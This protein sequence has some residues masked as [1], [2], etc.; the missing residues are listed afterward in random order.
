MSF[1]PFIGR[2]AELKLLNELWVSQKAS[3]LLLYG[4]RRVGKTR[5]LTHWQKSTGHR[6]LYWVASPSSALDQLRSFSHA[7]YNFANPQAKAPADFT[8]ATW[9]QA[10]QQVANLAHQE[11]LA[12]FVDEFT[13]LLEVD[14]SLA[15][16]L[17]NVWDH[18]LKEANLLLTLSGSHLGMMQRHAL[19]YQAPLYGRATAQLHLQ[20]LPFGVTSAF[21]P[22]YQVAERVAIYA[23]FGG[24]PA[25]WERLDQSVSISENIRRQLLTPNNLMQAEPR[26]LLADF[27]SQ[28]HNYVGIL[29]AI[30]QG[31]RLQK[32]I[33][34]RTGL[35][36]GHISKYLSV[37]REAGFVERRVSVT[38][39]GRSRNGRYHITDPY[40]RFYYRFLS[41][42]QAQL[43]L[44]VH[45]QALEEIKR[46]LLDFIGTH[47]WEELSR[48]WLLRAT[49]LGE[50]PFLADKVGRLWNKKAQIDVAGINSMDKLLILGECKWSPT[51]QGRRVLRELV[52]KTAK[53]V[54]KQGQW[55][56]YYLGFARGRWKEA[57][58]TFAQEVNE[59]RENWQS[60]GMKLLTLEEV[61]NDLTRWAGE[62][63]DE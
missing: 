25:Y 54:P 30:A 19:S 27:L 48:E 18:L 3:L 6:A 7:L 12:L 47:T 45:E 63:R 58:V 22:N 9:E 23:I 21:F 24:I 8:Y 28:P 50:L 62:M 10:W 36:S 26:L 14:P 44:G 37:L 59:Q 42:R 5:L 53:V 13:Y 39:T 40:L 11:R 20:P 17:Q 35:A 4:R 56:I 1:P 29:Q 55:Q 57:A 33:A 15:G 61:D 38:A 32:E 16:V 49:A 31:A 41:R 43:A 34:S 52:A 60:I 51:A 2:S 46:H